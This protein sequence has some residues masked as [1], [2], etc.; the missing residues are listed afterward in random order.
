M[1]WYWLELPK[2]DETIPTSS[3]SHEMK[4]RSSCSAEPPGPTLRPAASGG[5]FALCCAAYN[6]FASTSKLCQPK[7]LSGLSEESSVAVFRYVIADVLFLADDVHK[8]QFG[9]DGDSDGCR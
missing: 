1:N 7:A 2:P 4:S 9:V 8:P 6:T 5:G 3:S